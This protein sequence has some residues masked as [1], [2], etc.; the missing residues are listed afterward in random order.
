MRPVI[1]Y[2]GA[3]PDET[4]VAV[5]LLHPLVYYIY[6]FYVNQG[7]A[8]PLTFQEILDMSETKSSDP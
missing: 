3:N 4:F 5:V 2:E 8:M 7:G 1:E 6:I